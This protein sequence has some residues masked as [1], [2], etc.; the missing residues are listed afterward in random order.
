MLVV[1]SYDALGGNKIS[2]HLW[3]VPSPHWMRCMHLVHGKE[4]KGR[5]GALTAML[6]SNLNQKLESKIDFEVALGGS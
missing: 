5:K 1:D 3:C 2:T 4:E 6:L